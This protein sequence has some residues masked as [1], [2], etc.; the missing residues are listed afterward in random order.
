MNFLLGIF[1]FYDSLLG[2]VYFFSPYLFWYLLGFAYVFPWREFFCLLEDILIFCRQRAGSSHKDI[3]ISILA[4]T[5]TITLTKFIFLLRMQACFP[6]SPSLA[7]SLAPLWHSYLLHAPC[8]C[9]PT[10]TAWAWCCSGAGRGAVSGGVG[11][12]GVTVFLEALHHHVSRSAVSRSVGSVGGGGACVGGALQLLLRSVSRLHT[13]LGG[14][15]GG[16]GGGLGGLKV[17]G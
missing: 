15:W 6:G 12:D 9:W 11:S 17:C 7:F 16:A 4:I 2:F 8:P 10:Y 13:G 3:Q 14:G 5:I 1:L